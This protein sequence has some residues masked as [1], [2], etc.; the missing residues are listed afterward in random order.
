MRGEDLNVAPGETDEVWLELGGRIA[1]RIDTLRIGI[2]GQIEDAL[3][4]IRLATMDK[5]SK[6]GHPDGVDFFA[7][8]KNV[9]N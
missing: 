9:K 3:P 5:V 7:R 2:E 4:H 6:I 8:Q 1:D